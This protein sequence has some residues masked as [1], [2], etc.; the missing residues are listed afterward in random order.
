M[1]EG[2]KNVRQ[3][4]P[5]AAESESHNDKSIIIPVTYLLLLVRPRPTNDIPLAN[6]HSPFPSSSCMQW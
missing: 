4:L 3:L 5:P 6:D 2:I 1:E